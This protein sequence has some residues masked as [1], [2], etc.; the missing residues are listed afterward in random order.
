[1]L[2]GN[3]YICL[4]IHVFI[5]IRLESESCIMI[6]AEIKFPSMSELIE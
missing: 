5:A 4:S 3:T 1:M 2:H 6:V